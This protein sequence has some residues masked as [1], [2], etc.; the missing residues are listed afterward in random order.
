MSSKPRVLMIVTLDTKAVEAQFVRKTL[1][2]EG[3]DVV[4]LDAS[5]R[6]STD[7]NVEIVRIG[8]VAA[9]LRERRLVVVVFPAAV[10]ALAAENELAVIGEHLQ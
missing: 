7:P 5:I 8:R 2:A 10:D 4:H 9:E 1:E 6:D 3:V